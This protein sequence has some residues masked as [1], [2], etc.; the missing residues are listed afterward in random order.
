VAD[1]EHLRNIVN[2]SGYLLQIDV[3]HRVRNMKPNTGWDVV[4]TEH[5]WQRGD[6]PKF[7]DVIL[8]CDEV[9][10]LVVEC[11]RYKEGELVFLVPHDAGPAKRARCRWVDY[12]HE[13]RTEAEGDWFD[14]GSTADTVNAIFAIPPGGK[15]E[16]RRPILERIGAELV[17]SC[18]ALAAE[19]LALAQKTQRSLRRIYVP[20]IVTNALLQIVWYKAANIDPATGML[21]GDIRTHPVDYLWFRKTL[22]ATPSKRARVE[23]LKTASADRERSIL[24]IGAVHLEGSLRALNL[25]GDPRP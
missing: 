1:N 4:I 12:V 14:F 21:T 18:D 25:A 24:I 2:G 16:G 19:E 3:A 7:I 22:T 10:R 17:E 15:E 11:K 8:S 5:P 13:G 9:I 23:D 6:A 20:A